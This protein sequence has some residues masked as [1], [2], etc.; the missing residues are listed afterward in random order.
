MVKIEVVPA[1]EEHARNIAPRMRQA[2]K[3]EVL[4][5][6][7]REPLEALLYSIKHSD[8]A[9]TGMA[10]G[11]PEIMFGVG[12]INLLYQVGAPWLLGTDAVQ[13]HY[14]PFLK[15]SM[16]WKSHLMS[17]YNELHNMVDDRN[18]VSKR[19]LKWLGFEIGP[20]IDI[21]NGLHFREFWMR[22]E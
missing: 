18:K 10:D 1:T 8:E 17:R 12:T 15:S 21:G 14:R 13:T 6:S 3:D 9:F 11:V 20:A 7:G 19:W 4:A 5:S 22:K 16:L 2:D